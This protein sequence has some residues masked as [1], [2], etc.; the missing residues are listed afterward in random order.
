MYLMNV[1]TPCDGSSRVRGRPQASVRAEQLQQETDQPTQPDLAHDVVLQTAQ[2]Q[3]PA[4][5]DVLAPVDDD[6]VVV[7]ADEQPSRVGQL[8]HRF[9][10]TAGRVRECPR[11]PRAQ[12]QDGRC[13]RIRSSRATDDVEGRVV[14]ARRRRRGAAQGRCGETIKRRRVSAERRRRS[15]SNAWE[16]QQATKLCW[17]V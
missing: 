1:Y 17:Q 3:R 2:Q 4:S 16:D 9:S 5:V 12:Q 14:G 8:V 13:C 7:A 10:S 15:P 6:V 11:E